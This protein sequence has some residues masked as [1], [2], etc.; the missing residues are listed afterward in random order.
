MCR[1]VA[2]FVEISPYAHRN[3]VFVYPDQIERN[4]H[5]DAP[6]E[7]LVFLIPN[8]VLNGAVPD[9]SRQFFQGSLI[10]VVPACAL[11]R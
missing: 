5:G 7:Y 3:V 2:A 1:F 11:R 8:L 9:D 10:A 6:S 4:Q